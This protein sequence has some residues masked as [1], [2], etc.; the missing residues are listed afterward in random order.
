MVKNRNEIPEALTWDL[1]TI[2]STDQKW[3]TELEKVKKE[4][5]L[6]ETNDKGHLLDSAETL[7]TITKNML[8]IS[9][10][11]EKLYVYASM[12]NDQDTREAKYQEYQ[13]KA[14]ALYVNFGE[15]YAFYEP[16]FLKI[17]KETYEQWLEILQELKNYDHMFERLFAKKEHI[18]S[19]KEEK[20]LAA[21][22]EIFESPSETFEILDNADVKFPF[23]KNELG[24]KIQLTHGNYSSL[25]ESKNREVRKAAYEALYSNYE[26]YQHTYAKT[27]Q[28]NVKVH[29]F[30][31]QIRAYDSARQAALMSNFV[32][33]KVYDVLIEGIHQHLPL[34]HR[35]IELRKKILGISDFKMYDI[36]TPLSNLDYKFN[37]TEGV[38]KAQEVLA[39][40]GEE[41]SQKVKAAFDERWIDVEEN[42]GKRSGAYS[43]GSYDTKA[44][45]LLNWQGTLDD[46]F[47][48]VHEMGHSIHSTFT[49]ENQPYV[50]GDYPIFLAEIASTTNENIL[51]ETLL[52][53]SNDEK[54]RF[55]L[56]NHWLDSFRGTVFRQSQFAEFEQKIHEVDAEG[57][58]LTSEFLNSLYGELNEKYYGL[59]A[60]ENPEIQFEW[61]RIPH[62]YYN[63]YVFQ[64]ATGFAAASFLAEK[65]VHGSATDRQN[66]LDYLKAGSSAYPL[67]VIAKAGVNMESTDYLESAF[68]LFEK[69]LNELE[70]LVEKGVHL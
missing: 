11:V 70:K 61:A 37:Y 43:G 28:T 55:A 23:V 40:F 58:V 5:S 7:L 62:F 49:R 39:I 27:L 15:S 44:F 34:L 1:T 52:K 3:E 14:T 33:E 57:E 45:M 24:E 6:V 51:T 50:Y 12:K 67:D 13:S 54:E 56:L 19:Q 21:A 47:T 59:S 60:K 22:G 20:I 35:Y 69:R 2:F 18:L 36:Y 41:Y 68:K 25:M 29:N 10:K 38:K 8:S 63:F 16:E 31:A 26:Q 53:E 46:L 65:V 17:T 30:N 4:L 32:P 9:Q 42:V 66:Y 64:Y 48:L